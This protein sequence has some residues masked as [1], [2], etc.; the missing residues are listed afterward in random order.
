MPGQSTELAVRLR[1]L[2]KV[3]P[4]T[5][6][7]VAV[8]GADL[9]IGDG[10]FFSMLGPSG[11]GKTTVLRMIAGFEEP[12]SGSVELGGRDVTK[13]PPYQRDVNTV[14]QDYAL[15]P[16][17]SVLENVEYGLRVMTVAKPDRRH[18]AMAAREPAR[19][20]DFG[21]LLPAHP[22]C[23]ELHRVSWTR[24]LVRRPPGPVLPG[25]LGRPAR[26]IR[27]QRAGAVK[28]ISG[29]EKGGAVIGERP[30]PRSLEA[31]PM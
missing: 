25:P 5:P 12:T 16:H 31:A 10:E 28:R 7:V 30:R 23:W 11:S 22:S 9:D 27:G 29:G 3:F 21:S 4:G 26:T 17:L 18:R 20:R 15:F 14:F 2:R 1:G 8:A 19:P 6:P 24:A 13:R